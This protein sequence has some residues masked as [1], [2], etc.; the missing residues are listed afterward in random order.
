MH[1]NKVTG[2]Y[3]PER[4]W[5]LPKRAAS[6]SSTSAASRCLAACLGLFIASGVSLTRSKF[7]SSNTYFII[8]IRS[9]EQF[10]IPWKSLAQFL[11]KGN[12]PPFPTLLQWS[13]LS[14]QPALI[15]YWCNAK[16]TF[17]ISVA[18]AIITCCSSGTRSIEFI[19]CMMSVL[20]F[21]A[22]ATLYVAIG[23]ESVHNTKATSLTEVLLQLHRDRVDLCL[24]DVHLLHVL[25]RPYQLS[26]E[27][28]GI[29]HFSLLCQDLY[30]TLDFVL[31]SFNCLRRIRSKY[32][33][34]TIHTA[35]LTVQQSSL[36]CKVLLPF[37]H[38]VFWRDPLT[39]KEGRYTVQH[40]LF[41]SAWHVAE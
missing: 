8:I 37:L 1:D 5:Y 25:P 16:V 18:K 22:P 35:Y 26:G 19:I 2:N 38:H 9:Q 14:V 29:F 36:C 17:S 12:P 31:F 13:R 23:N 28:L 33:G 4:D 40:T 34:Y 11:Q 41:F 10:I 7:N 6:S 20:R 27:H 24:H 30:L 32:S 15:Q 21:I 39:K 3:C